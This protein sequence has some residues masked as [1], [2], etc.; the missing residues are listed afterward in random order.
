MRI[1]NRHTS[2]HSSVQQHRP[3]S[4]QL[5]RSRERHFQG[6]KSA[7]SRYEG[8]EAEY[9]S[10][11]GF[12]AKYSCEEIL[13]MESRRKR[14]LR[15]EAASMGFD[16]LLLRWAY[17]LRSQHPGRDRNGLK[18]KKHR[19]LREFLAFRCKQKDRSRHWRGPTRS[20]HGRLSQCRAR[21]PVVCPVPS[22]RG[23]VRRPPGKVT[24]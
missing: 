16:R 5:H 4:R 14:I 2:V 6:I 9:G 24:P 7:G 21:S 10:K 1:H 17:Y 19:H 3:V 18:R 11:R 13:R 15:A 8:N 22:G 12:L 20:L 23:P